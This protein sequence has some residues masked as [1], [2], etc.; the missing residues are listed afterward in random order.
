M[1]LQILTFLA[2][3]AVTAH[4]AEARKPCR[5]NR[6]TTPEPANGP[7]MA[8]WDNIKSE[9]SKFEEYALATSTV[10]SVAECAEACKADI[11]CAY[12]YLKGGTKCLTYERFIPT[13]FAKNGDMT[14][15]FKL[16]LNGTTTCETATMPGLAASRE[17]MYYPDGGS[18]WLFDNIFNTVGY[19]SY[20]PALGYKRRK[21][22][23]LGWLLNY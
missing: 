7:C 19:A 15:I 16:Y 9:D 4:I 23:I 21:R 17:K 14:L 13:D 6:P 20:N 2:L 1:Q 12:S 3:F 11:K 18:Y 5:A 8:A 22:S 10:S